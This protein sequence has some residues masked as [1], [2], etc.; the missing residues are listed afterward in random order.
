MIS[1][2]HV[3]TIGGSTASVFGGIADLAH[4]SVGGREVLY[5]LSRP[6]ATWLTAYEL[7]P[8]GALVELGRE[9]LPG[10]PVAGLEAQLAAS[11]DA[12][13]HVAGLAA[14]PLLS[15][16][17]DGAGAPAAPRATEFAG[18]APASL[19]ALLHTPGGVVYT[20]ASGDDALEAWRVAEDGSLEAIARTPAPEGITA[21][22]QAQA[23]SASFV[24][25]AASGA[26]S[27][28][29]FAVAADGALRVAD[30][31]LAADGPGI[32]DPSAIAAATLAGETYAIVAGAG[33]SSLTVLRVA[34]DG[35]LSVA[36]HLVDDR[37]SRFDN[38]RHLAV[39]SAG[40][41]TYVAAAGADDGISLFRLLPGGRL[42]H[43][44]ALEE[45]EE[46]A[47]AD[48]SSIALAPAEGGL[49]LFSASASE[50]AIGWHGVALG[51][52]GSELR[53]PPEGGALDGG[54]GD[55]L[56]AG[57]AGRDR[58]AGGPGAD[59][60]M[61]GAGADTLLGGPGADVFVMAWDGAADRIEG[62]DPAEDR[63]DLS[64]WRMFR[65]AAQLSVTPVAGGSEIR[66]GAETLLVLTEDG[67]PLSE[68]ALAALT[69]QG[70][71][72]ILPAWFAPLDE[73]VRPDPPADPTTGPDTLTGGAVADSIRALGGGDV[74]LGGGGD[75][76]L[77]GNA[78]S[79][80]AEGEEGND[81]LDG[82]IGADSLYGGAG[83]DTVT[84][85]EGFDLIDG[86]AD[87]DYL[88][89]NAGNDTV[90]GG[91]GPDTLEGGI[92]FDSLF[93]GAGDDRM[94][95]LA[96]FDTLAGNG[97]N[98]LIAG[99]EGN[100][101]LNGGAGRDTLDGGIGADILDGED[102]ADIMRGKGG[103]D[104]LEGGAGNDTLLGNAWFDT[105]YGG[106][107]DDRLEGGQ[108][109]DMIHGDGGADRLLGGTGGD[110]LY[111]GAGPDSLDGGGGKIGRAHV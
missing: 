40:G 101:V 79:D 11:T 96:G 102:G 63:I 8:S 5:V 103:P 39:E 28:A 70:G 33:S 77:F 84:G 14:P 27:V 49:A 66:F 94:L 93:G 51:P 46:T 36:D 71:T 26:A 65:D 73:D 59:I 91:D 42:L 88:Q 55:D 54:E 24:L 3:N 110:R 92:G 58:L 69:P 17:L 107:G 2:T 76:T 21:L 45:G 22:A 60:L 99:N 41:G 75:D 31:L 57:G 44:A 64:G 74:I 13:L 89:G 48:I 106:D 43:L 47:L 18:P 23:G 81:R 62:Y 1:L 19:R 12:A 53:A 38:I 34:A 80:R 87:G 20:A 16:A 52:D 25:A 29:S 97:G 6:D 111:G 95:G 105:L 4:L 67:A 56:L 86:G 104:L 98:D 72:R 30:T 100:D 7:A 32:A 68:E 109:P 50:A 82:G 83:S 108:Q 61:D 90:F 78:G 10:L 15:V 9:D 35:G 37:T 85:L